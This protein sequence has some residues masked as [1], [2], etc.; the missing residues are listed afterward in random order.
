VKLL[1]CRDR[2]AQPNSPPL[3][4][5]MS[6]GVR[7][8]TPG[9]PAAA[10]S[11]VRV[12]V[13]HPDFG[14]GGAEA[15]I[16]DAVLALVGKGVRARVFTSHYDP[17]RCFAETRGMD[18]RVFGSFLPRHLFRKFHIAFATARAA[19]CALRAA[20]TASSA[21]GRAD[22]YV[23]DQISAYVLFLRVFTSR[24]ILFYCH[25]PDRLLVQ[26]TGSQLKRLYRV[27]F[28]AFE[29]LTTGASVRT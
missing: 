24:P 3:L 23:C 27:P 5:E 22:V 18:V 25:F 29:E 2:G 15:L 13:L 28:D 1:F 7:A 26:S 6:A 20:C 21:G 4:A 16:R 11:S 19:Y 17:A 9:A 14:L 8:A 10:S 12:D